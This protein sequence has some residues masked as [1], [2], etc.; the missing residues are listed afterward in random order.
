MSDLP[1]NEQENKQRNRQLSEY[2]DEERAGVLRTL[3][4]R[5]VLTWRLFWDERV[6]F[7][8][9]LIP[10]AAVIY[11]LSPLDFIT[12][13]LAP[14]IGPLVVVDDVGVLILA[15]TLFIQLAPP[16]VVSEHL[17]AL[18]TRVPP[19]TDLGEDGDVVEGHAEVVDE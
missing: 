4:N 11:T 6:S 5:A 18:G 1:P 15:L 16:D 12:E 19:P 14:V 10:V 17:H 13:F 3:A 7:W 8:P 2:S 9:K